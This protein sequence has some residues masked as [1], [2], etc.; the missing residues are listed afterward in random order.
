MSTRE[1]LEDLPRSPRAKTSFMFGFTSPRRAIPSLSSRRRVRSDTTCSYNAACGS[2]KS[3]AENVDKQHSRF[4]NTIGGTAAGAGN[5][6]AFNANDGVLVDTGRD[7]T[8]LSDLIYS[9]G[10]LGIEL[11]NN[12]NNNQVAPQLVTAKDNRGFRGALHTPNNHRV[13]IVLVQFFSD[14]SP[15]PSGLGEGKQLL[16]TFTVKTNANGFANFDIPIPT[17]VRVGQII[18]ATSTD[19]AGN[20]SEFSFPVVVAHGSQTS[21]AL[22]NKPQP[23]AKTFVTALF[24]PPLEKK[25]DDQSTLTNE[26]E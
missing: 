16:G 9:S 7:N 21:S 14:P 1:S 25:M 26:T 18:T 3:Q 6:I 12:G 19:T 22:G 15:D 10:H 24:W 23:A 2:P 5:T 4:A 8:I 11:V 20:T 17:S 13:G